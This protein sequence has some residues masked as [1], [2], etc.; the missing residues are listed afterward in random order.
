[1]GK[2]HDIRN[3]TNGGSSKRSLSRINK[4]ARHHSATTTGDYFNFWNGRWK[5]LG[6]K[7]GGYHE[8]I[9]RDGSVQICYDADVVTNGIGGHNSSTYHICLVGD[10]SFTEAQETTFNERAKSAMKRFGLSVEDVQG[11]NEFSGTSTACPGIDMNLVR[12]RLKGFKIVE[13]PKK[14]VKTEVVTNTDKGGKTV[15]KKGDRGQIVK[16]IQT[17]VKT[18]ADGIFGPN[19]ET[20]VK[21]FQKSKGLSQDG[22]VGKNTWSALTGDKGGLL[23]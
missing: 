23:H 8:L 4:I 6:W 13:A 16:T 9:L 12:D 21:A 20:K 14:Q 3:K 1:M 17:L 19:T 2:V 18:S 7:T 5:G 15:V 22:I 11:H 10:G